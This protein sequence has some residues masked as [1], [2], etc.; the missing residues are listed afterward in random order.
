MKK[1]IYGIL[2]ASLLFFGCTPEEK[3]TAHGAP[4]DTGFTVSF[5]GISFAKGDMLSLLYGQYKA[6]LTAES[7]GENVVFSG[8]AP[9]LSSSETYLAIYPHSDSYALEG[10]KFQV[11]LPSVI[12]P[13]AGRI[14]GAVGAAYATGKELQLKPVTAFLRFALSREDVNSL[15]IR[16]GGKNISG[17]LNVEMSSDGTPMVSVAEGVTALAITDKLVPGSYCVAVAPEKINGFTVDITTAMGSQQVSITKSINLTA[18]ASVDLGTIDEG[19]SFETPIAAPD[20]ELVGTSASSASVTWSATGFND[21]YTDIA[22]KWSAGI[23]NDEACTDLRVSWNFPTALWNVYGGYSINTYEGPYSP[24]FIFTS[25]EASTDYYVKVWYTDNPACASEP[26]KVTTKASAFKTLPDGFAQEGTVILQEDFEELPWGG[27]VA[28]RCWGLSDEKR[29]TA[30]AFDAPFGEN[31]LGTQTIGGFDHKWYLVN[32]GVEIGLFNTLSGAISKTRL[33][34][35]TSIA[36]DNSDGK[37]LAKPGYVKLGSSNKTGGIVTPALNCLEHRALVRFS[38]KAHPFRE[39]VNDPLTGSA[40]VITSEQEGVSVLTAYD[41]IQKE[42]FTLGENHEWKEYSYEFLIQP[43]SRLAVSSRRSGTDSNQRRILVDDVKVELIEYRPQVKVLEIKNAQDMADFLNSA[44]AYEAEETVKVTNDIDLAGVS[45]VEAGS[46]AGILDGQN[47]SIKNWTNE[48]RSL[49]NVLHGT[50]KDLVLDASCDLT[51]TPSGNFGLIAHSVQSTGV[52][53]GVTVNAQVKA[54]DVAS[55]G[56]TYMGIIAGVSYGVIQNCVNNSNLSVTAAAA[57]ANVYFGGIVGFINSGDRLGLYNLVNNGDVSY[58]I[59][60]LGKFIYMGGISAGTSTR[61][62]SEATDS[63]GTAEKC[64]NTGNITY[65]STNGGSLEDNAGTA[66]SG[67]YI[68]VG[69][70]FGYFEGNIIDCTN[71]VN[72]NPAKGVVSVTIPT[73]TSGACATGTSVGGVAGFVLRNV[74]GCVNY[75]KVY[76]KGTFA[77]GTDDNQGA[78]IRSDFCAGGIVAQAGPKTDNASYSISGCT[79]YGELDINSWMATGNGSGMYYGGVAGW[80]NMPADNCANEGKVG[81]VSK[82]AS[83]IAGGVVGQSA[84]AVGNLVNRGE[85]NVTLARDN[86]ESTNNQ[87]SKT[88]HRVGGI[89]GYSAAGVSGS[90]NYGK[91]SVK[92]SPYGGVFCPLIGGV[93]G[94]ASASFADNV[95]EGDVEVSYPADGTN[96]LRVAGLIGHCGGLPFSGSSYSEGAVTVTGGTF[97]TGILMVSGAVAYMESGATTTTAIESRNPLKPV[98]VNVTAMNKQAYIAGVIAYINSNTAKTRSALKNYKPIN[99]DLGTTT[100]DASYSYIAGVSACDKANQ[101]FSSCENYGNIDVVAPHKTRIAGI[102]AYTNQAT[103]NCTADCNIT[104]NLGQNNY[105]EVGGIIGYTAATGFTGCSFSGTLD[106]SA[107]S[108]KVYTGGILGK[109]NGN[110]TFNGC[111]VSGALKANVNAPGLYIGG[112]QTDGKAITFGSSTKCTV[113]AGTTLNGVAVTELTNDNLVS[114]SSDG[115]TFA[116]TSTLTNIVIE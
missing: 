48:G 46:F 26:L 8:K 1:L 97:S 55:L 64:V 37:A 79:N 30:P 81:I 25:L 57:T 16:C 106:T 74:T 68:K 60:N 10:R 20:L 41:V 58:R 27:D 67:N 69:G 33:A 75:G 23:Y 83:S 9:K 107:S 65:V 66:G 43:G 88:Y 76:I 18:G 100:T 39:S 70:V 110:Q 98:T 95:N 2:A 84:Y 7:S 4:A 44:E 62:A 29:S 3:E 109:S 80:L 45:V 92:G 77:G 61:K 114:Q 96:G 101:T 34:G 82:A 93:S 31:P 105:S 90:T 32:P 52:I 17:T 15:V 116:S 63:R 21:V 99:V 56:S 87:S 35:W 42:D 78:G 12:T 49:V 19:L 102:A 40:L 53:D 103:N 5:E 28:T 71:G 115:G 86:G 112:L 85:V 13:D 108:S 89:A 24:R 59:N 91:V 50:V 38:F 14:T 22:Q 36:E 113:G 72:G 111:S 11:T 73:S 47:H 104:A 54:V 51:L 94:Q 6:A